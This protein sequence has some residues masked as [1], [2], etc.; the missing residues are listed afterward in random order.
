MKQCISDAEVFDKLLGQLII[1]I[2]STY[3]DDPLHVENDKY[4]D[5]C[6]TTDTMFICKDIE[7]GKLQFAGV[8]NETKRKQFAIHQKRYIFNLKLSHDSSDAEYRSLRA[9]LLWITNSQPYVLS[10]YLHKLLKTGL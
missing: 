3:V 10:L 5:L 7:W 4:L 8:E 1:G 9:K 2:S 6:K